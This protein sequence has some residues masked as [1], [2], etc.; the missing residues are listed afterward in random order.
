MAGVL[1]TASTVDC[2]HG[3]KVETS[4]SAKL[5][6]GGKGV[7]LEAGVTGMRVSAACSTQDKPDAGMKK[8]TVVQAVSAGAARKLTVDGKP[9]LLEGL[10][11]AT[12][13]LVA[14]APQTLVSAT[15]GQTKLAAT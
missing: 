8:C 2:G 15:A 7:L 14:G 10:Q 6:V 11:G 13:G 9:V 5:T 1:T 3:G 12:D 4:G